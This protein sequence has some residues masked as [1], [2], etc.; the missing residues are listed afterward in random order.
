MLRDFTGLHMIMA[1]ISFFSLFFRV[2]TPEF[3]GFS[4]G[5]GVRLS[6]MEYIF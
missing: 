4:R 6:P 2:F 1:T 3:Q 5:G